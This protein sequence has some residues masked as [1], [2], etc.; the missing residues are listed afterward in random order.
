MK[1]K[2]G[3][4]RDIR[5]ID[6]SDK[7]LRAMQKA[8]RR[9]E[10]FK[11]QLIGKW[12]NRTKEC[13]KVV[14]VGQKGEPGPRGLKGDIGDTRY[15]G[16][17]SKGAKGQ[18]G[19]IGPRGPPG[20]SLQKPLIAQGPSDVTGKEGDTVLFSCEAK[21]NPMPDQSWKINGK[22]VQSRNSRI[23]ITGDGRLQISKM[24][25]SDIGTVK[26]IAK[27]VFGEA[28]AE[29]RLNI[30]SKLVILVLIL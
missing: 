26:C 28:S 20:P 7:V 14:C 22:M 4:Q 8:S 13:R 15:L 17:G 30:N 24:I 1:D 6:R 3:H 12:T 16:E 19:E 5:S 2:N 23:K 11:K 25:K 27:N 18:K 29:A 9:L 21:G 10:D